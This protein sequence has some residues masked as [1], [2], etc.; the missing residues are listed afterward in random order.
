M[1]KR[2]SLV[3]GL[4]VA[5][6]SI[7]MVYAGETQETQEI[8]LPLVTEYGDDIQIWGSPESTDVLKVSDG[9]DGA[10]LMGIDGTALTEAKY[11]EMLGK[12]GYIIANEYDGDLNTTGLLDQNG[13]EVIPFQYE[14]VDILSTKWA[15]GLVLEE[16]TDTNYDYLGWSRSSSKYWLIKQADIYYLP[17]AKCV[18][19]LD[20]SAYEKA[21]AYDDRIK[22]LSRDDQTVNVYDSQFNTIVAGLNSNKLY[23]NDYLT[24]TDFIDEKNNKKGLKDLDGKVVLKPKMYG[25]LVSTPVHGYY[26]A[27]GHDGYMLIT[28]DGTIVC[29]VE[30][31]QFKPYSINS[32]DNDDDKAY[33][34]YG[35]IAFTYDDDIF[36]YSDKSGTITGDFSYDENSV[37]NFGASALIGNSTTDSYT[38]LAADGVE[39]ALEEYE[40]VKSVANSKGMY[41]LVSQIDEYNNT[42]YGLIDWHGETVIPCKYGTLEVTGDGKYAVI[43]EYSSYGP[44]SLYE[45]TYPEDDTETTE[46][47]TEDA[48][49][50]SADSEQQDTVPEVESTQEEESSTES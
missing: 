10:Y 36:K 31:D 21:N 22:I 4:T 3:L 16:S 11:N 37:R 49:A 8:T 35:Y 1:K 27:S 18:A 9:S 19:T 40:Y 6:S 47:A 23:S 15:V 39:T 14:G 5:L 42:V 7:S 28:A 2:A 48:T 24:Y 29:P 38:L 13:N 17:D 32:A 41:Y 25:G 50:E 45:L 20:R 12:Y 43:S 33:L 30:C 44:Y 26:M 34:A 46:D